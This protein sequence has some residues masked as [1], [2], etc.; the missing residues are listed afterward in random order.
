MINILS[1]FFF[2]WNIIA[3][4]FPS[5]RS[6]PH[7]ITPSHPHPSLLHILRNPCSKTPI[8]D[9]AMAHAVTRKYY[10]RQDIGLLPLYKDRHSDS[11]SRQPLEAATPAAVIPLYVL[12][13][14]LHKL[15]RSMQFM[16]CVAGVMFFYL[17]YGYA[18]VSVTLALLDTN[19]VPILYVIVE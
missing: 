14:P 4:V 9:E 8:S 1:C 10:S 7:S 17:L 2:F 19:K 18:Q 3:G 12:C 15:S 16:V 13:I 5:L 6:S 11:I